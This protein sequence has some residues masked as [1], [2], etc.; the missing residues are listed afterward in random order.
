MP[1]T[2]TYEG[3][4]RYLS[5]SQLGPHRLLVAVPCRM[6]D[7]PRTLYALLDTAAEWC[8]LSQ[9]AAAALGFEPDPDDP[10][11][12]LESRLGVFSGC[13]ARLPLSLLAEEGEPLTIEAT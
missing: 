7:N 2:R 4:L 11:L 1:F 6:G 13:L 5:D 3:R 8:V 9:D 12:R 10:L